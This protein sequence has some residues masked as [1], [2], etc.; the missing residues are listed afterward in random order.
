MLRTLLSDL[1][2][3]CH[4]VAVGLVKRLVTW[5]AQRVATAIVRIDHFC[6]NP[7]T[8]LIDHAL[9]LAQLRDVTVS[10]QIVQ[11]TDLALQVVLL[12]ASRM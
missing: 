3:V 5:H 2:Q 9:Q 1:I 11:V 6:V 7:V 8:Q 10:Q 12:Q 4:R